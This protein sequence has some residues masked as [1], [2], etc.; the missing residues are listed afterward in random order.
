MRTHQGSIERGIDKAGSFVN[1]KTGAKHDQ[2][3][4]KG[5]QHLRTGL[6]KI[7]GNPS[8]QPATEQD[9]I[10]HE[11]NGTTRDRDDNIDDRPGTDRPST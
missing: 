7:T 10:E 11:G 6:S 2:R 4:H 5:S 8:G 9:T 3:I 1:D